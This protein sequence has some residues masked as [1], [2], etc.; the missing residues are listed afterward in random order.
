MKTA[1]FDYDLPPELIAQHPLADREA[2]RM[3]VVDRRTAGIEHHHVADLPDLLHPGDLLVVNDTRVIPARLLGAKENTGGR[4][5][6]LLLEEQAPDRWVALCGASRRP[7]PGT[8]LAMAGGRIMAAVTA[9]EA[10]GRVVVDLA[11]DGPLIDVLDEVG[12]TPLPPYI[13]RDYANP[14]GMVADRHDY[15]TVFAREPGAVA[16]PTAGLHLTE[17]LLARLRARGVAHAAVT[18]HVG[19]GTFKPMDADDTEDHRMEDERFT[20]PEATAAAIAATREKGGRVVAVGSTVVR[21]L[22]TVAARH[23]TVCATSGR[24]DLFIRPPYAFK[25]VDSMLTNFH[26]PRSTLIVMVSALA[27]MELTRRAYR[28][29]VACKYRFYSYGDC[30]LIV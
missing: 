22:E 10:D 21:T 11:A 15:Q 25:V 3:M 26:L 19:L 27:G 14:D 24:T 30:M 13:K 9:W 5:E 16:A 1:D 12:L 8:R 29:A 28:E 18:L 7:R 23:G 2:A 17:A 20:I 4:V 6:L